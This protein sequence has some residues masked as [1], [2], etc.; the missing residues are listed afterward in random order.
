[1][2]IAASKDGETI[3]E[4]KIVETPQNFEQGIA[5][6][7][8]ISKELADGEKIQEIVGGIAGPLDKEKGVG[9]NFPN[10]PG[11]NGKPLVEELKKSIDAPV[12]LENDMALVGLGEAVYG[13]AKDYRIAV[14]ITVSSGVGGSRIVEQKI[15]ENALGFEPG[16]QIINFQDSDTI[17]GCGGKAHLEAYVSGSAIEKKYGKKPYEI[18]DET[19]WDETAKLLAVGLNNTIV[20]WSPN[21]VVLGGSMITKEPGISIERVRYYLKDAMRIFPEPPKIEQAQLQDIGGLYGAL[22]L[23]KN[24]E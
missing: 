17:C 9:F 15:D 21:I 23:L 6:F 7:A 22:A 10:L 13:A 3:A 1:M 20:H 19:I 16:H 11:W 2:R 24:N 4:T 18:T 5:T 12:R 8:Q 14:Y